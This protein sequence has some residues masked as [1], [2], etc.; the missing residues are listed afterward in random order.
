MI[1]GSTNNLGVSVIIPLLN[2]AA[3]VKSC[4]R[5]LQKNSEVTNTEVL[6]VDGGSTD[7]SLQRIAENSNYPILK[8][9]PGRALQMNIGA[10]SASNSILYFLHID[11]I[12][13]KGFD[14]LILEKVTEGV[15][16]GC[17]QMR[18]NHRHWALSLAGYLTQFNYPICRGGDQSL[19]I[20]KSLFHKM[21]GYNENYPICEDNEFTDR[22]YR[23][24]NFVVLKEQI[25]SSARRFEQNGILYLQCIYSMIHLMR[26]IGIPPKSLHSMYKSLVK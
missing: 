1:G 22:L 8:S 11:S 20:Q 24:H 9:K 6:F 26:W 14:R 16:A 19:F 21:K 2:E 3:Y 23:Q 10:K 5:M 7:E 17:F 13:P 12:P 15:T 4:I 25:T 18:F